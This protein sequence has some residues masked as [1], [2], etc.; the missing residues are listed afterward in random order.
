[1]VEESFKIASCLQ[2]LSLLMK[3][4]VILSTS[5]CIC[6]QPCCDR[7]SLILGYTGP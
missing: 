3:T 7:I 5:I 1:M 4:T 2:L 6:T